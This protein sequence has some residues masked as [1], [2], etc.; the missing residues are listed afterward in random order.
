MIGSEQLAQSPYIARWRGLLSTSEVSAVLACVADEALLCSAQ[1]TT[2]RSEAGATIELPAS[3][4]P[5]LARI[6]H[7]V[8]EAVGLSGA[9]LE[10]LRF[11]RYREGQSHPAHLDDY[12]MDGLRLCVTVLLGLEVA[13]EGG[14]THFARAGVEAVIEP[15][16]A[17]IWTNVTADGRP[18][19]ASEH[20]ANPVRQGTKAT[21][22]CFLYARPEDLMGASFLQGATPGTV[23][24]R[25]DF[26]CLDE[27]VP[28]ETR[29]S[30]QHACESRGVRYLSVR[31]HRFDFLAT[32]PLPDGT[33]LFRPATSSGA[34][35]LEQHLVH[36]GVATLYTERAG[37]AFV[38][39][40]QL[41]F[42]ER[43][44]VPVP[45]TVY[46]VTDDPERLA[47]YA[48]QLGG[49]PLVLKVLGFS[50]GVGV[51]QLDSLPALLSAAEYHRAGGRQVYLQA[52]VTPCEH[53]RLVVVGDAV[54][55][56]YRNPVRPGDFRSEASDNG[57]D[58]R[59][60]PPAAAVRVALETCRALGY[61]HAGVD[62]LAHPSGRVY[63]LEANF[64]CYFG[65][66]QIEGGVDVAGSILDHLLAKSA[67]I[68]ARSIHA[69]PRFPVSS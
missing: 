53:W 48:E 67:A 54:V 51:M 66:A 40:C 63:V 46:H 7:R 24:E 34:D 44:G 5:T 42:L 62:V 56:S 6:R 65:H 10:H 13:E 52:Q 38:H 25:P 39:L 35:A 36:D 29:E 3:L 23:P 12:A 18:I 27:G 16:D 2:H 11:R 58:Y 59:A 60:T 47:G 68:T 55:A 21:L 37:H 14:E 45:R 69:P 61:E 57:D 26:V 31:S 20:A 4:T 8:L 64:P 9:Q 49:F 1:L 30:L 19:P 15:G 32:T 17:L 28:A 50:L 43:A 33:M 22:G 41:Q